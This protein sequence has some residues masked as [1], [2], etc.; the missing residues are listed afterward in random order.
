MLFTIMPYSDRD[1]EI[2]N[3]NLYTLLILGYGPSE[4][5]EYG[6]LVW[7]D[8]VEPG[9]GPITNFITDL[10]FIVFNLIKTSAIVILFII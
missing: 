2:E 9:I 7:Q 3:S 1:I 4:I 8:C 10:F 5:R 6:I